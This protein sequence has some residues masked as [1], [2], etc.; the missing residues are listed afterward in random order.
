MKKILLIGIL[1][2]A[3]GCQRKENPVLKNEIQ[4]KDTIQTIKNK[5]NID[6]TVFEKVI[7]PDGDLSKEQIAGYVGMLK[8]FMYQSDQKNIDADDLAE[9]L[10]DRLV[11]A[12]NNQIKYSL[13]TLLTLDAELKKESLKIYSFGFDCGGTRGFITYPI[14]VWKDNNNKNHAFNLSKYRNCKFEQ[15]HQ[16][17]NN[18]LLLIGY[19]SGS[20]AGYQSI[21]YV[22]EIKNNKLNPV[23]PAFV[24]R[25]FINFQSGTYT[26][27]NKKKILKF[28]LDKQHSTDN[29]NDVFYYADRYGDFE[30]DTVSAIKLKEMIQ[31]EYYEERTFKL[32]FN[33]KE[34]EGV[35]P[36]F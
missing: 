2:I 18:L 7:I 6:H 28:E 35:H 4:P 9:N 25:P 23:Y 13:D 32:K 12:I 5:D 24:K 16:L 34:F 20:G 22:I 15:V 33:G 19:E 26:F 31:D 17:T 11:S 29:L 10:S 27:S 3:L 30:T 1:G 8:Y 21:A 36:D 14:V